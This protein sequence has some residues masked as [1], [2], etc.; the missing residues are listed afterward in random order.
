MKIG[1]LR[2]QYSEIVKVNYSSQ[3]SLYVKFNDLVQNQF[4]E[5][6]MIK[7]Y[8]SQLN[9]TAQ[10][11]SEVVKDHSGQQASKIVKDLVISEARFLLG[12]PELNISQIA[13]IL[14]FRDVSIFGKYFK[15]ETGQSPKQYRVKTHFLKAN[16]LSYSGP[17]RTSD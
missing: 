9:V 6:R 2:Q 4:K 7:N 14:N 16:S 13:D 5:E 17:K 1:G 11:L 8:A 12:N 10:Y 3:E 15:N